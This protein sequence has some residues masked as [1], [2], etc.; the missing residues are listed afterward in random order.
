MGYFGLCLNPNFAS[1]VAEFLIVPRPFSRVFSWYFSFPFSAVNKITLS[2]SSFQVDVWSVGVIFF[3]MLYGKKV[4]P[5]SS[6]ND[7]YLFVGA[8]PSDWIFQSRYW[9]ARVTETAVHVFQPFGHNQTQAAILE[10]NTI[11]KAR[12]VDFPAKPVV[13]NEAKVCCQTR[14]RCATKLS[15]CDR[16]PAYC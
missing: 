9:H 2:L 15:S 16:H 12:E 4:C 11:L 8:L 6:S 14:E 13:S 5:S 1:C 10:N 3:Q 7:E